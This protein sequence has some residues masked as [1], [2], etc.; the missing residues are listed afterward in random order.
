MDS[1]VNILKAA[2]EH[3]RGS[4][5]DFPVYIGRSQ[6]GHGFSFP[7][8]HG[9]SQTGA[10]FGD[11]L[12]GIWRFFRPVAKTGVQTLL[13]SASEA[14]KDGSTI[15]EVLT[16]TLKPTIGA[17]LGATA[18]QVANRFISDKPTAS[19]SPGPPI[20][21]TG[22]VLVGTQAPLKGY[23]KRKHKVSASVYKRAKHSGQLFVPTLHPIIYN[24]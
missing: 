8:F 7:V 13:K 2:F 15:K 22:N 4:G 11:V 23:R 17:V 21:T 19:P 6:Y 16:S 12:R 14:I 5:I 1:R 9:R 24:F 3:Q 20:Y 18:E 10:G